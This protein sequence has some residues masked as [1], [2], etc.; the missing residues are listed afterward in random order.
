MLTLDLQL[1]AVLVMVLAG[2]TLALLFDVYRGARGAL[3]PGPFATAIGD[4]IYWLVATVIVIVALVFSTWGEVRIFVPV[5][6]AVG[7]L[8]YR[9]LAG[10]AVSRFSRWSLGAIGRAVIAGSHVVRWLTQVIAAII[11]TVLALL[12]LAT[13]WLTRPL[14]LLAGALWALLTAPFRALG[15]FVRGRRPP[16]SPPPAGS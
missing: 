6:I 1:Y 8:V 10:D 3:D 16:A 15:R 5:G 9:W 7:A 12:L 14:L 2:V 11:K 13:R 4:I